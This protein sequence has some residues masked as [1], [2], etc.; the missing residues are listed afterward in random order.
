MD[1]RSELTD[2]DIHT[3]RRNAVGVKADL[4][5]PNSAFETLVKRLIQKLEDPAAACVRL[6]AEQIKQVTAVRSVAWT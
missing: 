2:E 4:F 1:S 6:V 5:V 3:V